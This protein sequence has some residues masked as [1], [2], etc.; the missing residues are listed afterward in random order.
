MGRLSSGIPLG[1]A[2]AAG[3]LDVVGKTIGTVHQMPADRAHELF[4]ARVLLD[5]PVDGRDGPVQ[6]R[7]AAFGEGHAASGMLVGTV[8]E[9][10]AGY[11]ADGM[12]ASGLQSRWKQAVQKRAICDLLTLQMIK[13]LQVI[14]PERLCW[15]NRY[16]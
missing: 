5:K 6:A 2:F 13:E 15:I 8:I 9:F 4:V 7:M 12:A 10:G 11:K 3:A 14:S 16:D 1:G